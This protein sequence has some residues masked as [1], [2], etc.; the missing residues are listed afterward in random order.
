MIAKYQLETLG[1]G[2]GGASRPLAPPPPP[3]PPASYAYVL[4]SEGESY[5]HATAIMLARAVLFLSTVQIARIM[6][7]T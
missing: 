5:L 2:G 7:P 1:G 3:P 4:Y 6:T